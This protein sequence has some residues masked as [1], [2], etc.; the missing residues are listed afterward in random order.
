MCLAPCRVQSRD[1]IFVGFKEKEKRSEKIEGKKGGGEL[2]KRQTAGEKGK[3]KR[4]RRQGGG[5]RGLIQAAGPGTRFP[6]LHPPPPKAEGQVSDNSMALQA[7][8]P[9]VGSRLS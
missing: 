5:G 7:G 3:R 1:K 8:G 4:E 6:L 2:E 9:S